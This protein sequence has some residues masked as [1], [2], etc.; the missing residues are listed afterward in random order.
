MPNNNF[1]VQP[2][3]SSPTKI[4]S[5]KY[6]RYGDPREVIVVEELD[7]SPVGQEQ[8]LVRMKVAPIDPADLNTIEG[9]YPI[10]PSL[11]AVGG[12]EGVGVITAM[13]ER[14]T[15][16]QIGQLVKPPSGIGTWR[17][18]FVANAHEVIPFPSRL[19]EEQAAMLWINP[20]TAFRMLEDFVPLQTGDWLIQNA[21]NSAVG[22]LVIQLAKIRGIKTLNVVRRQEL[23]PELQALGADKVVT[24]DMNLSQSIQEIT[25]G[26]KVFLGLNAVGG[27][28]AV[29]LAKALG[30]GGTL[31]TYGGM[32][33][34][35][36]RIPVSLLV[37][38][39]LRIRGF[40]ITA[41]Y[42]KASSNQIHEMLETL[43]YW[44]SENKLKIPVA[45]TYPL[46][47]AKA[48][49]LHAMG[50]D[51]NGKILFRFDD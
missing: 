38:K 1:V 51:R 50:S 5:V 12:G 34:Q 13:G 14:V 9:T 11:P 29:N 8:V 2:E 48:A 30:S 41:W 32:S 10:L 27:E 28:N 25:A 40:W 20:P 49:I 17:E 37:F 21:A 35:P 36:F 22:R 26:K 6:Y 45:K 44:M 31:V 47:E 46:H 39:D 19:S 43:A 4:R 15:H 16:L 42:K 7:L 33:R 23:I 3:S 24:D 18:A